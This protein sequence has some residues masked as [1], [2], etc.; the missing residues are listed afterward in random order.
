ME[1]TCI[2]CK[3]CELDG[4]DLVCVNDESE[5]LADF[6]VASHTCIDWCANKEE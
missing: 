3:Y 2:N 4:T 5:Y 6:V 1:K